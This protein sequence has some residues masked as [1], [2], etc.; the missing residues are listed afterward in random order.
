MTI[1]VLITVREYPSA[2]FFVETG[3]VVLTSGII[4]ALIFVPKLLLFSKYPREQQRMTASYVFDGNS[5]RETR[6]RTEQSFEGSTIGADAQA[7]SRSRGERSA[8]SKWLKIVH[9]PRVSW[10]T[11][12]IYLA[13][14]RFLNP[15]NDFLQAPRNL[16]LSG[17][18]ELSKAQLKLFRMSENS[19]SLPSEH[20]SA[21]EIVVTEN[22]C[23]ST[24]AILTEEIQP[25]NDGTPAAYS[26]PRT[27]LPPRY[28]KISLGSLARVLE[29]ASDCS[30]EDA[31]T[32]ASGN[33]ESKV[34]SAVQP[35]NI[36][37]ATRGSV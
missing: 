28:S 16:F 19:S 34:E 36:E 14:L 35:M 5:A 4:I 27:K 22:E 37:A 21:A 23:V 20:A 2:S 31:E 11:V 15:R 17:G 7:S 29:D 18:H 26:I 30:S 3:S 9:N 10:K 25:E 24:F 6:T 33:S 12:R 32:P 8:P 13:Q 1:P